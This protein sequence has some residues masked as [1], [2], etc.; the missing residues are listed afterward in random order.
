MHN[1]ESLSD[2]T[3]NNRVITSSH[4][5]FGRLFIFYQPIIMD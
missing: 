3:E 2:A 4:E 5:R 1:D